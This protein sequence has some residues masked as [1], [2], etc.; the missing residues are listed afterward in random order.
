[1]SDLK[2]EIQTLKE[3]HQEYHIKIEKSIKNKTAVRE[4]SER[5]K[6]ELEQAQK[7][8]ESLHYKKDRYLQLVMGNI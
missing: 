5:V 6:Q 4:E 1:M 2:E 7:T 8:I 3:K